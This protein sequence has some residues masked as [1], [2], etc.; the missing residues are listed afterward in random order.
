MSW[1]IFR[2]I[3]YAFEGPPNII[4][5]ASSLSSSYAGKFPPIKRKDIFLDVVFYRMRM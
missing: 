2:R 5:V 3:K 1:V 4:A